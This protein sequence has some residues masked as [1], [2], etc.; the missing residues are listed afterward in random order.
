MLEPSHLTTIAPTRVQLRL[1]SLCSF[2]LFLSSVA[3]IPPPP[4]PRHAAAGAAAARVLKVEH[5][6][7]VADTE[8]AVAIVTAACRALLDDDA[9]RLVGRYQ[10]QLGCELALEDLQVGVAETRGMDPDKDLIIAESRRWSCGEL[11]GF[12][13]LRWLSG[14]CP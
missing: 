3:A 13:E 7:A 4:P 8:R 6:D 10:R 14:R 1:L 9:R 5:T 2:R 11:V 12:V